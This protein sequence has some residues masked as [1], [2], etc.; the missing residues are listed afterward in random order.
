MTNDATTN[1]FPIK[2]FIRKKK[3]KKK[4]KK[5]KGKE[6]KGKRETESSIDL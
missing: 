3:K 2:F 6:G 4:G 1:S 5:R